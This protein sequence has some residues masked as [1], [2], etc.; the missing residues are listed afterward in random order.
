MKKETEAKA[1][2][3]IEINMTSVLLNTKNEADVIN[4]TVGELFAEYLAD[5]STTN[6][7]VIMS[8]ATKLSANIIFKIE[9]A[10][11]NQVLQIILQSNIPN[12]YKA[13]IQLSFERK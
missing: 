12:K 8:F 3:E 4:M 13:Q 2:A 11:Y 9:D 6:S 1:K 10:L 7:I 5:L